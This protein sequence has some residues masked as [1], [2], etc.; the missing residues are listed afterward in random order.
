MYV[1]PIWR[2]FVFLTCASAAVAKPTMAIK[3]LSPIHIP[4]LLL[5]FQPKP[6]R[7]WYEHSTKQIRT[8]GIK[9]SPLFALLTALSHLPQVCFALLAHAIIKTLASVKAFVYF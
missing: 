2:R 9:A 4:S 1:F 3:G 7:T 6:E 5:R 8:K